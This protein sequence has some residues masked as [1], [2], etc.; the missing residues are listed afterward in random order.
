MDSQIL[1]LLQKMNS[2]LDEHSEALI[3]VKSELGEV[4]SELSEVKSELSEVKSD[5]NEVKTELKEV[6]RKLDI[7]YDQTADL[8]EFKTETNDKLDKIIKE[9]TV[10]EKATMT[11]CYEIAQLKAVK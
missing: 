6:N 2:K 9:V 11:N 4:K 1:E 10:M 7:I 3:E 8:T 5:L